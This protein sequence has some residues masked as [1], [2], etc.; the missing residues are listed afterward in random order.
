MKKFKKIV[1]F[2][3]IF[4]LSFILLGCDVTNNGNNNNNNNNNNKP[5]TDTI[6]ILAVT[7]FHGAI[8]SNKGRYGIARMASYIKNIDQKDPE[9]TVVIAAGDM[10]QGTAISNYNRGLDVINMM[11]MM[12]FDAMTIGNHE[13]DWYLD[14]ILQYRDGNLENGEADFPFL[15]A[16]IYQK[17][18]E[19]IPNY[20]EPY[21]VIE[22]GD[23]TI[24]IIGYIGYGQESDIQASQVEDYQFLHPYE[25]VKEYVKE[26]RTEKDVD[27]VIASG[28]DASDTV[29]QQLASL[30]GE[31]RVDAIINGHTHYPALNAYTDTSDRKVPCIQA[32]CNGEY[33]SS[34]TLTVDLESGTVTDVEMKNTKMDSKISEDQ[35]VLSYVTDL[36]KVTDPLFNEV[37]GVAGAY[38]DRNKGAKWAANSLRDYSEADFAVINLGGIRSSAFPINVGEEVTISRIFQIMPFENCLKTFELKGSDVIKLLNINLVYSDNV[39]TSNYKINGEN[40]IEDATYKVATIDY[41]F[42]NQSYPFMRQN[43]K[44]VVSTKILF[45]D[46]LIES[47]RK[48]CEDGSKWME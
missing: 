44:N 8:E 22:K 17:S 24:G 19:D 35:E 42:D 5:T 20:V 36:K 31:Y 3:V 11:N 37:L 27:I 4:F 7:D 30:Q 12:G 1:L 45:R 39:S 15:G 2:V 47:V 40:I 48:T 26:M 9:G 10:F 29:N 43:G 33:V 14:T 28:H 46:I 25:V 16:N 41:V 6:N 13:F 34:A 32:A 21:T 38:F 23:L 18:I